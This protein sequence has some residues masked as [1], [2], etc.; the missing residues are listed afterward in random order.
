MTRIFFIGE[1]MRRSITFTC[2]ACHSTTS[3]VPK[4]GFGAIKCTHCKSTFR[5]RTSNDPGEVIQK[6][7]L[8]PS[9]AKCSKCGKADTLQ[10]V[11]NR[12]WCG[13][14]GDWA[15]NAGPRPRNVDSTEAVSDRSDTQGYVY[16]LVNSS[17]PGYV[18]IGKTTND[19]E[20]RAAALYGT[21]VPVPFVVAYSVLVSDCHAVERMLHGRLAPFRVNDRREF[22]N[23]S[24]RE[25]IDILRVC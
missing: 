1:T 8:L 24:P 14:C 11:S 17:M 12:I 10:V 20:D 15:E 5:P 23:I 3:A 22:F 2:P 6:R 21:G 18:K 13:W 16:V 4:S 7:V 19:P 9:G 25:A